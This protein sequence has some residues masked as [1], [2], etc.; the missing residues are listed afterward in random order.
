MKRIVFILFFLPTT[1]A[2]QKIKLNEF[3][4][5]IKQKRIETFPLMLLSAAKNKMA[6][7]F[8]S[9]G[10]V[11]YLQ[12]SGAGIGANRIDENDKVILLF[13]NDSTVTVPSKGYQNY[14]I[15]MEVNS[16]THNYNLTIADLLKLNQNQ[17]QALRK[18]HGEQFDDIY[19]SK[20]VSTQ[21]NKLTTLFLQELTKENLIP[22]A[23]AIN[24]REVANHIGDSITFVSRIAGSRYLMEGEKPTTLLDVGNPSPNEM[25]SLQISS[26]NMN[27]IGNPLPHFYDGKMVRISG[28]LNSVNGKKFIPIYRKEQLVLLQDSSRLT[29]SQPALPANNTIKSAIAPGFPGGYPVWMDFLARNLKPP[30]ELGIGAKKTVVVQFLVKADG[31]IQNIQVV[32]SAGPQ[33]D[34]EVLRVLARMPRWKAAIENGKAVDAI[35]TQ[36]VTFQGVQALKPF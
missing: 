31:S 14:E 4:K 9:V 6:V 12:L 30:A 8:S 1:L 29:T 17:L 24:V 10:P 32:E 28:R 27:A 25:V 16:Y 2:A 11:L 19:I 5:F 36:P 35:V 18:Y 13:T 3:D 26:E 23:K 7:T 33:F 20:E 21:F 34:N 22:T 15:G